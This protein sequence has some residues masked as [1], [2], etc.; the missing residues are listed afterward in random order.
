MVCRPWASEMLPPYIN[1]ASPMPYEA[2]WARSA[3]S[4]LTTSLF[5]PQTNKPKLLIC[6]RSSMHFGELNCSSTQ[7]KQ[8]S[9]VWKLI[10]WD[11]IFWPGELKL[12]MERLRKYCH[13]LN[14]SPLQKHVHSL[15]SSDTFHLLSQNLLNKLL[16]FQTS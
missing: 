10:S 8:N 14:L 4:T 2:Y 12:T 13:G 1:N 9:C 6:V 15:A 11:T 16:L 5:R 7:G 3:T